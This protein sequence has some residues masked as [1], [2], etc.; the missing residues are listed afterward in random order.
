MCRVPT[1]ALYC[2]IRRLGRVVWRR[3]ESRCTGHGRLSGGSATLVATTRIT[4]AYYMLALVT[5]FAFGV[6]V[7]QWREALRVKDRW[8]GLG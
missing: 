6:W 8:R 1:S 4:V 3:P 5:A 7:C 2:N